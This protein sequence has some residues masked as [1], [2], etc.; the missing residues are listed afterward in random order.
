MKKSILFVFAAL[1]AAST[2]AQTSDSGLRVWENNVVTYQ[3]PVDNIDSI[4]FVSKSEI[5]ETLIGDLITGITPIIEDEVEVGYTM[6][7]LHHD[8]I[9]IYHGKKGDKGDKGEQGDSMLQSITQDEDSVYFTLANGSVISLQKTPNKPKDFE[10]TII[11]NTVTTLA[12]TAPKD[13]IMV[14]EQV[15]ITASTTPFIDSK[16]NWS[17]SNNN[18]ANVED[19]IVTGV[20]TGIVIIT[21][22]AGDKTATYKIYVKPIAEPYFSISSN[23]KIQFSPGNLQFNK[24]TNNW[25]FAINQYDHIGTSDTWIDLF[26]FGSSGSQIAPSLAQ[27]DQYFAPYITSDIAGTDFD[28]GVYNTIS[29]YPA[30]TWRTMKVDEW[31]Y[32]M[33]QRYAAYNK[34]AIG[35]IGNNNGIF[36]LPDNWQQPIGGIQLDE[37]AYAFSTNK[38]SLEEWQV[39]QLAGAVFLPCLYTSNVTKESGGYWCTSVYCYDS[40]WWHADIFYFRYGNASSTFI[41][42]IG[43]YRKNYYPTSGI[44]ISYPDG[45]QGEQLYVRLVKDIE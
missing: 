38:C 30:G 43:N 37:T 41:Y 28:W 35:M 45:S 25:R 10:Q 23:K 6:S 29:D 17:S 44:T 36:I 12:L 8:P 4:T 15:V 3:A 32:L 26:W 19:G 21:A 13:T 1:F 40:K 24:S 39:M 16:K 9:N 27:K 5:G 20:T 22:Q 11:D 14:G 2:I 34:C 33:F 31:K 42:G 18:V 7:F